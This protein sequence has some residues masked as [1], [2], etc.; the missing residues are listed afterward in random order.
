[1]IAVNNSQRCITKNIL[2]Y[3]T[4]IINHFF[5]F[6]GLVLFFSPVSSS[7]S[8]LSSPSITVRKFVPLLVEM[9]AAL[10]LSFF[11]EDFLLLPDNMLLLSIFCFFKEALFIFHCAGFEGDFPV[12]LEA[13]GEWTAS[14]DFADGS[15]E[16]CSV[17]A[18]GEFA[19]G[20]SEPSSVVASPC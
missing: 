15:V 20:L 3:D 12:A 16:A 18:S 9:G 19:P 5:F 10:V 13:E 2:G 8:P 11:D 6:P 4:T 14:R 1:M 7:S 17:V